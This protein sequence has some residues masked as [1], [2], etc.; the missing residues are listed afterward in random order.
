MRVRQGGGRR[1]GR[2]GVGGGGDSVFDLKVN[3]ER[4]AAALSESRP[5]NILMLLDGS[6][7]SRLPRPAP[8]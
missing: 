6:Q 1:R 2:I 5:D 3:L 8:P 7:S 4:R